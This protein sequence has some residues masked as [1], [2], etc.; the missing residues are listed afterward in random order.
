MGP[1]EWVLSM[2]QPLTDALN[3][4][5][6]W[7]GAMAGNIIAI[8]AFFKRWLDKKEW[9]V[10]AIAGGFG[11]MYSGVQ[12]WGNWP[13]LAGAT[14]VL[15]ACTAGMLYVTGKGGKH[16]N[17]MVPLGAGSQREG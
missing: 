10:W 6:A 14:V 13:A 1:L 4:D 8:T 5:T 12:Y 9:A 3:L 7:L 2:F 15:V 11:L 17:K 16:A